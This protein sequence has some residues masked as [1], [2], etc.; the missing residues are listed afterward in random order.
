MLQHTR[1]RL[2]SADMV[3]A[4]SVFTHMENEDY[5]QYFHQALSTVFLTFIIAGAMGH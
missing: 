5:Y 1:L 4:F 2:P 3:C